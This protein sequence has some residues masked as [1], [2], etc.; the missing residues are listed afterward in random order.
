MAAVDIPAAD[1]VPV[2]FRIDFI[3]MDGI[4]V[5]VVVHG[6]RR[7]VRASEPQCGREDSVRH[8]YLYSTVQRYSPSVGAPPSCVTTVG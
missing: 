1:S 7:C 4:G 3:L 5:V 6:R 2:R 8:A